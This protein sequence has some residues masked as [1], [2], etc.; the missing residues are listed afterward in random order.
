VLFLVAGGLAAGVNIGSRVVFSFWLPFSAAV[1]MAFCCSLTSAFYMYRSVV[2]PISGRV[3]RQFGIFTLVNL[4]SLGLT[5]AVAHLA[6]R[7]LFPLF[8]RSEAE[9]LAHVLGAGAPVV[10]NFLLHKKI[11]F[12]GA[13]RA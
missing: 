5:L 7:A 2:F 3:D 11:T 9:F 4:G 10:P 8:N 12:A 1:C 13:R 6:L